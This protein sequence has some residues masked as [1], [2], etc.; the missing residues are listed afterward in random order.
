MWRLRPRPGWLLSGVIL[1]SVGGA[2]GGLPAAFATPA[3]PAVAL[4]VTAPGSGFT[5]TAGTAEGTLSYQGTG[6]DRGTAVLVFT[7]DVLTLDN[8]SIATPCEGSST[9]GVSA[10]IADSSP[11]LTLSGA[12]GSQVQLDLTSLAAAGLAAT[13][14]AADPPPAGYSLTGAT[15]LIA[16]GTLISAARASGP[17]ST[18]AV[19]C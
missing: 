4:G 8:L 19:I 6:T 14:T 16:S 11:A 7:S 1:G 2:A 13:Y 12:A 9:T 17:I 3:I 10:T 15:G 5:A 18:V